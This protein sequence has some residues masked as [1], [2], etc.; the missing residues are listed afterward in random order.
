[1]K[2][3]TLL[4]KIAIIFINLLWIA[5]SLLALYALIVIILSEVTAMKE[6]SFGLLSL[7]ILLAMGGYAAIR[8]LIDSLKSLYKF[9]KH[10]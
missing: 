4:L 7:N 1:M 9:I 2:N 8:E 10:T 6:F 3:E 5:A